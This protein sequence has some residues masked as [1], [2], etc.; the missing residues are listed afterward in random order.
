MF[1]RGF[2]CTLGCG[3]LLL[4]ALAQ[5]QTAAEPV[6]EVR[7]DLSGAA[8]S[9]PQQPDEERYRIQIQAAS[10]NVHSAPDDKSQVVIRVDRGVALEADQRRGNWYRVLLPDGTRG[11]IN[12]VVG[13]AGPEFSVEASTEDMRQRPVG[14]GGARPPEQAAALPAPSEPSPEGEVVLKRPG[15]KPLEP[16]IPEIN[17]K[18]VPPPQPLAPR[19][20][21]PV[22]DRWRLTDQ[23]QLVEQRWY[24]PYNPNTLKGDRPVFGED[25]FFPITIVS[26]TLYEARKL[27]TPIGAQSTQ[28]AQSNDQF[29]RGRQWTFQENLITSFA[30]LKGDTTFKPPELEFRLVPV[31][32]YN[33]T[34]LQEVRGVN[35]DPRRG[36]RRTDNFVGIQE[37]FIDYE[38]NITSVRYDFDD[39]RVGIQ[40]FISDFR[41][42]LFVDQP[43]GI[44]FFGNRDNNTWQYN[45]A[46]FQRLEK[47]TNSGLNDVSKELRK[48]YVFVANLYKQD[49]YVPGFTLQGTVLY[50]QNR[51]NAAAFLD[52]NGFQV[53]PAIF[54]D[55][56]PHN[57]K[58]TYLGLNG[59][60]HFGRW[61]LTG[62]LYYAFGRDDHNQL[63]QKSADISAFYG[64]AEVSRDFDWL[65]VR[66]TAL[67]ATGDRNPYDDKENGFDAIFE[68]PQIAGAETSYW[69]RQ[70]IPLI[71]GGGV[72]LSQRNA[73]LA[74]LRS[75]KD[76]GQSNFINPGVALLG[77]GADVDLTP[78]WRLIGNLNELWFS[79]TTVLSVLRNQ[80]N[81]DRN[82]GTDLS[83]AVQYRP[84]FTQ[85]IVLNASAAALF[86]GKGL[87]ELYDLSSNK[88]QYSILVNLLLTY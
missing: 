38:Y 28:N 40:P 72:A 2:S 32:N 22:P 69:I 70:A 14:E 5:G 56:R 68:N 19:E 54:G 51:E 57:Y 17:P 85:N 34:E 63:S 73:V 62:A 1:A 74:S 77:I 44:R 78:R 67:Y 43:L 25:W 21:I 24:D 55:A 52:N 10:V 60:G 9:T 64:V 88:T 30:L 27:P 42:F 46:F 66:G 59:D 75:S 58:V 48:D 13:N 45:V 39:V 86:P 6:P 7:R 16:V 41:G 33:V 47:D 84:F 36:T 79:N 80:G 53:R 82:I 71:G 76:Q 50:N 26:D 4:T 65:R 87:K 12:E 20:S 61:N 29:G 83:V 37:A 11:W 3:A 18:Q 49:F 31:F 15:G 23:L 35:I 8:P 81:I